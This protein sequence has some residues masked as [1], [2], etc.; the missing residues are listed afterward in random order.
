M[1]ASARF[2]F[3]GLHLAN[4][5]A[6]SW[7]CFSRFLTGLVMFLFHCCAHLLRTLVSNGQGMID[8]EVRG[9]ICQASQL[10]SSL[11]IA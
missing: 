1:R 10:S 7:H 9:W 11:V 4:S 6:Y 8:V 3:G 2:Q 5:G